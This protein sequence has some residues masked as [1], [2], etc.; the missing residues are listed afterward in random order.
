ML[1]VSVCEIKENS[2]TTLIL[3]FTEE[4]ILIWYLTVSLHLG[5]SN[6]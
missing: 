5:L 4:N 3:R 2:Y 1:N 6:L